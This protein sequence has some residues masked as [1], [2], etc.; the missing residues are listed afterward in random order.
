[1]ERKLT[2]AEYDRILDEANAAWEAGDIER[3]IELAK[4]LPTPVE[5]Q[6][7]FTEVFGSDYMEKSGFNMCSQV[8][9]E[10]R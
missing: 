6:Q 10:V 5:L 9:D 3:G 8:Y 1:M 4:Q 7:V 2:R